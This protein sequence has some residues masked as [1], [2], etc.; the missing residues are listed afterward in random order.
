MLDPDVRF[1]V[2]RAA[3]GARAAGTPFLS[4]FMP[5]EMLALARKVGFKEV[6]HV[7]AAS[8]AQRQLRRPHRWS[9]SPRTTRK[10]C[11]WPA[12]EWAP[13]PSRGSCV[14]R[15]MRYSSR[16]VAMEC[17]RHESGDLDCAMCALLLVACSR[18]GRFDAGPGP[19]SAESAM[20][21]QIMEAAAMFARVRGAS[22]GTLRLR[23]HTFRSSS[24]SR[25]FP[26]RMQEVE[27]ACT[28]NTES[29]RAPCW[30]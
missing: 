23:A 20:A 15:A 26:Q 18:N 30:I 3:E 27:A 16:R 5:E 28:S 19:S 11:S 6:Q 8:I 9:T 2:E 12:P 10:K 25:A 13:T 24:A 29:S 21:T 17:A 1:G 4:F 7:S 22:G 14:S